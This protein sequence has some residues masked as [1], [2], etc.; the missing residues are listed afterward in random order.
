MK[1]SFISVLLLLAAAGI[2]GQDNRVSLTGGYS[3]AIIKD[4]DTQG[5]GW[6]FHGLYEF[7][8]VGDNLA[9]GVSIGVI[10]FTA[11]ADDRSAE[12]TTWPVCYAPKLLFGSGAFKAFVKVA[13]GL[14]TT[15]VINKGPALTTDDMDFGFFGGLGAGV[16]YLFNEKFF[17]NAEYE[18]AFLS[19]SYYQDGMINNISLGLGLRF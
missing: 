16:E 3:F 10:H 7:N 8:R 2:Y 12:V 18:L 1:H 11:S 17:V 9:H 5:S 19:N 4:V 14:H 15:K 6:N 13:V